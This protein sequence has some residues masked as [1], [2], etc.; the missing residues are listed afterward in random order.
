MTAIPAA[1]THQ[2]AGGRAADGPCG[3][4][5]TAPVASSRCSA[6]G[7]KYTRYSSTSTNVEVASVWPEGND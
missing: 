7:R 3:V 2:R 5:V 4:V 6:Y 1:T